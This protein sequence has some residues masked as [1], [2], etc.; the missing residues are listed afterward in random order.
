MNP[1]PGLAITLISRD[2]NTPYSGSLPGFL[3]GI[4]SQEDIHIDLRPLAQFAGARIIQEEI[5]EIDLENKLVK[6]SSRPNINFDLISL[7]IGSKPNI[8]SISGAKKF[9][10]GIKPMNKFI[11]EWPNILESAIYKISK[12]LTF[13]FVIVGGGPASVELAFAAQFRI[14]QELKQKTSGTSK[15]Q[16]QII[17]A[18]NELLSLH[19]NKVR[20]FASHELQ[21]KSIEISLNTQVVSIN[22]KTLVC[23]NGALIKADVIVYAT[24][25]SIPSWPSECGLAIS[26]DGFIEVSTTLQ[27]T[28]HEYVF[29]AG[30]A[31]TI[32]GEPRPKS[33][34]YAVRQGIPLAKN[35]V[36]YATG[37]RLIAYKVQRHALA[38]ISM[39]NK[40]AIASRNNLF[41][42]GRMIWSLK[43]RIDTSFI[44]KY[45]DFPTMNNTLDITR[46]LVD[47]ETEKNLRLHAIRCAGCGAKVASNVLEDVLHELP[48][49]PKEE[50][51]SSTPSVED[52]SMIKLGSGKILLQ[53]VDLIKSFIND[54]WVFAKI[55]TNHCLSDIYAM[56]C[57]P[58]SALAIVGLPFASKEFTRSQLRELMLSCSETLKDQDC[59]LIGGHSA[60]SEDLT[61][62]LCVNGFIEQERMLTKNGMQRG[63][64]LILT[65]PLGTGTLLA[66]DMRSK[67]SHHNIKNALREMAMSNRVASTIFAELGATSCTD[68]TGF[69]LAG[70]LTEML[71]AD[72][73]EV[74]LILENIPALSGSLKALKQKTFSSLHTDNSLASRN[75][76]NRK[77]FTQNL[78]YELLFDPQTSGGLLASIP[79]ELA[80]LCLTRLRDS[81]YTHA[82]AIGEVSN[83]NTESPTIILK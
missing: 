76:P 59:T 26:K 31:A 44:K 2:I 66:A 38:L 39:G 36:R 52:A 20:K 77:A 60:E 19:N 47:Q 14:H 35:L 69:G 75:I 15:L 9:G 4:Y 48:N 42:Q 70:H 22:G 79:Y 33:G 7:N 46:G 21:K 10:I 50:I 34:V 67:A 49:T 3:S 72:N 51:I 32:K 37:K 45:S 17:S 62:G 73:V 24:G 63:D 57:S 1:V 80:E 82:S 81:G 55:A 27:S 16:I 41:F 78:K 71:S 53:S 56:G 58:H 68:I 6:L 5:Q 18:D 11:A 28:S 13:K 74:E 64:I 29:A 23:K 30:D 25:A 61:F 8:A 43:H 40:T 54:P 65:N 12:D 83:L